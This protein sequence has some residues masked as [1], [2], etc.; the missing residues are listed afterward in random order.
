MTIRPETAADRSRVATLIARTYATEGA[1]VIEIT[2][3]L[4]EAV[5]YDKELG[6][7]SDNDSVDAFV[8]FTPLKVGGREDQALL[9]APFAVDTHEENFDAKS[10]V[11]GAIDKVAKKGYRYIFLLGHL[12]ELGEENY[13]T[14]DSLSLELEEGIASAHIL[15][16]DL[17][18]E[19]GDAL[20]GVVELPA[21]L[22]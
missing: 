1:K 19:H 17:G 12:E 3:K 16:K 15:V 7:V 5:G 22:K 13:S 2:S 8:L 18:D 20:E 10:F 21:C 11:E 6:F 14:I 4:R 9:L